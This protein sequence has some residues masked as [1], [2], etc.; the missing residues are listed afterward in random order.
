MWLLTVLAGPAAAQNALAP[1]P[2]SGGAFFGPPPGGAY[3]PEPAAV[4]SGH[5]LHVHAVVSG[6]RKYVHLGMAPQQTVVTGVTNFVFFTQGGF[7]GSPGAGGTATNRPPP[8]PG[9]FRGGGSSPPP[10]AATSAPLTGVLAT[11]GMTRLAGL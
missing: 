3:N 2:G 4:F 9:G 1:G 7:V 8:D 5:N 11:P 6:D 10:A